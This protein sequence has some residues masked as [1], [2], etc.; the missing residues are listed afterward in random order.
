MKE[1]SVY[2]ALRTSGH[3]DLKAG[4]S[5]KIQAIPVYETRAER[6]IST[7]LSHVTCFPVIVLIR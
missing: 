3:M 4:G 6:N 5:N 2:K 7:I 1:V